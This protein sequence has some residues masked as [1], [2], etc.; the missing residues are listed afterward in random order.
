MNLKWVAD[1]FGKI[2]YFLA[3]LGLF[4]AWRTLRSNQ[5]HSA[6]KARE[7]DRKDMDAFR[8]NTQ[9]LAN[10]K[11]QRKQPS[12][13]PLALPGIRLT[14]EAHEI[15]GVEIDA[16]EADITRAYKDKIK[17]FHPDRI[18]GKA[19]DQLKFYE[20][21]SATINKAKEEMI[22]RLKK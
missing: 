21:A 6:F 19:R 2:Q 8:K 20:E 12:A 15:L 4:A 18:Q 13:P 16:K 14:G 7:S 1:N 17:L 5:E 3:A 9:D 10:A 11:M 22:S